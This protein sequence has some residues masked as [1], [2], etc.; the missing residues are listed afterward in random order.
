[1]DAMEPLPVLFNEDFT[2]ALQRMFAWM[3]EPHVRNCAGLNGGK[4]EGTSRV[5]ESICPRKLG[6][7]SAAMIYS[8]RPDLFPGETSVSLSR[9]IGVTKAAFSKH[10]RA[11]RCAFGIQ[12][13]T[14][15]SDAAREAMR[16]GA[17]AGHAK[18]R[19]TPPPRG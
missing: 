16:L 12:T 10:V 18:R 3:T 11:F 2:R 4:G 14:M 1:M 9:K 19:A 5:V 15:R 8:L 7:R 17:F 13:R 6:M